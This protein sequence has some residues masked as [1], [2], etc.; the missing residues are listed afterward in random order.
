MFCG[1]VADSVPAFTVAREPDG[2]AFLDTRP[3]FPGH[4]LV[5]SRTHYENLEDVPAELAMHLFLVASKL[6]PAV[7]SL[8][9]A[10]LVVPL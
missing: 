1:I 4:V 8:L 10:R 3:V 6:V 5:V 2:V 7:K 9:E